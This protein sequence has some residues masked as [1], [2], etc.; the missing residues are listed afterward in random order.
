M[1]SITE[2]TTIKKIYR[3]SA[4]L[5]LSHTLSKI[6]RPVTLEE[7]RTRI[8]THLRYS[9]DSTTLIRTLRNRKYGGI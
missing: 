1:T 5:L 9:G 4:D 7:V 2:E 8:S 6:T 3:D